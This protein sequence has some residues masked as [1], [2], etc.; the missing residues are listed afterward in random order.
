MSS[1]HFALFKSCFIGSGTE[2]EAVSAFSEIV[3]DT[4]IFDDFEKY[5]T[6]SS[7]LEIPFCCF[8]LTLN[9]Y[10]YS[11]KLLKMKKSFLSSFCLLIICGI[12]RFPPTAATVS[13]SLLLGICSLPDTIFRVTIHSYG[14][15]NGI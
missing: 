9:F 11:F 1:F 2:L 10:L 4:V 5:I 6:F 8:F 3:P 7:V 14:I 15:R 13:S 12:H